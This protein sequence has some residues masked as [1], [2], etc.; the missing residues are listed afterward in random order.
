MFDD[1]FTN[2]TAR[3]VM[4]EDAYDKAWHEAYDESYQKHGDRIAALQYADRMTCA[5]GYGFYEGYCQVINY[6]MIT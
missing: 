1:W 4:G 2:D 6:R 5:R 3:K